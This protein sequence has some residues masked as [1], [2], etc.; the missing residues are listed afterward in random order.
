[1]QISN[2]KKVDFIRKA[3]LLPLIWH[4]FETFTTNIGGVTVLVLSKLKKYPQPHRNRNAT[5]ISILRYSRTLHIV[6]SLVRRRVSRRLSRL[7]TMYN[8]LK[9]SKTWW[10]NAK[11]LIYRNAT[12]TQPDFSTGCFVNLIMTSTVVGLFTL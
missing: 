2:S 3:S 7:Q 1:M 10:N 12:A 5:F 4:Q 9:Y 6:W 11:K 8:V